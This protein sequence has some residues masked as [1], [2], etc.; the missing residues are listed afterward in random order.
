MPLPSPSGKTYETL[1]ARLCDLTGWNDAQA[2][3]ALASVLCVLDQRLFFD[4]A[5]GF[6]VP[7]PLVQLLRRCRHHKG[8]Q[9]RCLSKEGLLRVIS[10]DLSVSVH[11]AELTL[12]KVLEAM[13]TEFNSHGTAGIAAVLPDDLL[14]LWPKAHLTELPSVPEASAPY[15]R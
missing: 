9:P 12:R 14:D 4:A 15:P 11:Q 1:K 7:L 13:Q 2:S 5:M 8:T 3:E 6:Q 10:A